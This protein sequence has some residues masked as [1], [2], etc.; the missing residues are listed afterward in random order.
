MP[1]ISARGHNETVV[2]TPSLIVAVVFIARTNKS[3]SPFSRIGYVISFNKLLFTWQREQSQQAAALEW[4]REKTKAR[5]GT[6][7]NEMCKQ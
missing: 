4:R 2:E 5:L 6:Y 3:T 1:G 7:K